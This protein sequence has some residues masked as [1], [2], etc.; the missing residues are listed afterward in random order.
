VRHALPYRTA[1]PLTTHARP[2]GR[3][4]DDAV[5]DVQQRDAAQ[6][7]QVPVVRPLRPLQ[8]VLQPGAR[9]PP[10][11]RLPR[12]PQRQGPGEERGRVERAHQRAGPPRSRAMCA[13]L[14]LP[15]RRA[16]TDVCPQR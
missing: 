9:D 8:V 1:H 3:G 4:Q 11:A 10:V 2:R 6:A 5:L 16:R 14:A 13:P 7:L 12:G 15:F